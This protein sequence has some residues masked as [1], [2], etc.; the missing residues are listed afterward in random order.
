MKVSINKE[1]CME[2]EEY[3]SKMEI[4]TQEILDKIKNKEEESMFGRKR[5]KKKKKSEKE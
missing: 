1:K 2:K 3:C 5:V 4:A